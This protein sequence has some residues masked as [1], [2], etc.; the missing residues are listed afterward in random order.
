MRT[1]QSWYALITVTIEVGTQSIELIYPHELR[2]G[3]AQDIIS[4]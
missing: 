1:R 4:P 3:Q 2:I